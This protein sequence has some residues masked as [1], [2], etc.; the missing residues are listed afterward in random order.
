M[1][2]APTFGDPDSAKWSNRFLDKQ[3]FV[4]FVKVPDPELSR[5]HNKGGEC[6]YNSIMGRYQ[7]DVKVYTLQP[8]N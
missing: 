2:A 7:Q 8:G 1:N 5:Y 6:V 4:M 3:L